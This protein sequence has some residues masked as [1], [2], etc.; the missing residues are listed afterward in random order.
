MKKVFFDEAEYTLAE[1]NL[2]V[3]SDTMTVSVVK[4]EKT[5]DE[6]LADAPSK[7]IKIYDEAEELVGYYVNY[8]KLLRAELELHVYLGGDPETGE[9][10]YEDVVRVTLEQLSDI[11]V[12]VSDLEDTVDILAEEILG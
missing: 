4:G 7:E 12:R 6:I 8:E 5:F 2:D 3:Q 9:A 11:D 1:S 10:I